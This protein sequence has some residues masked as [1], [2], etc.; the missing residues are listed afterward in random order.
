[1]SV[2][3]HRIVGVLVAFTVADVFHEAVT[4][5]GGGAELDRLRFCGR[6]HHGT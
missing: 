5:C 6:F 2:T 3:Y 4:A 1:M